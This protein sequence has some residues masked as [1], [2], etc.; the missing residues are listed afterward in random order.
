M[1]TRRHNNQRVTLTHYSEI[2][3]NY[4]LRLINYIL[5][6]YYLCILLVMDGVNQNILVLTLVVLIG[7]H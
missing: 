7:M 2:S 6:L 3:F 4:I 5:Y 1:N